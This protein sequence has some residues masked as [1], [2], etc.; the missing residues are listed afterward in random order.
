MSVIGCYGYNYLEVTMS[1]STEDYAI[2]AMLLEFDDV[3]LVLDECHQVEKV[4]RGKQF[5][6]RMQS[7]GKFNELAA[8][9]SISVKKSRSLV[10]PE[11]RSNIPLAAKINAEDINKAKRKA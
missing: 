1:I 7:N 11:V 10:P 4:L 8:S 2:N 3:E 5:S 9:Q 6:E